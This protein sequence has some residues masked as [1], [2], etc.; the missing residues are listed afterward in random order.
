MFRRVI[1][2]EWQTILIVVA[3]LL[4]FSASVLL[5]VCA[6]FMKKSQREHMANL[7][8]EEEKPVSDKRNEK[9]S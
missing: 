1:L 6:I 2:E 9:K 8:L 3:F 7:P 4:T 5:T